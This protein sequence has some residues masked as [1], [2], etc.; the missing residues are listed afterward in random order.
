MSRS[1][2]VEQMKEDGRKQTD[3]INELERKYELALKELGYVAAGIVL[4]DQPKDWSIEGRLRDRAAQFL[5]RA[6]NQPKKQ[7]PYTQYW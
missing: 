4:H 6:A 7:K 2:Y 1:S 5:A 3:Y